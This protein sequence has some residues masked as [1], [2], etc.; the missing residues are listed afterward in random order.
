M[1]GTDL[2]HLRWVETASCVDIYFDMSVVFVFLLSLMVNENSEGSRHRLTDDRG[3]F[4]C[5]VSQVSVAE[6]KVKRF[7]WRDE[8]NWRAGLRWR[9]MLSKKGNAAPAEP[10]IMILYGKMRNTSSFR[11]LLLASFSLSLFLT[12]P[13]LIVPVNSH[14]LLKLQNFFS[15]PYPSFHLC[16]PPPP[17][18]PCPLPSLLFPSQQATHW[19]LN[20]P[21]SLSCL[22]SKFKQ[23][24]EINSV[25][26]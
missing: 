20:P 22:Q 8:E 2:V 1:F 9:C 7:E 5:V 14:W 13:P 11:R 26:E 24:D 6:R 12:S 23:R 18:P 15:V 21:I 17:V 25:C 16:R 10:L 4:R 3:G 19:P